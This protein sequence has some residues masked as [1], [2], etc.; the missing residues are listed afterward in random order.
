MFSEIEEV[1]KWFYSDILMPFFSDFLIS[2]KWVMFAFMLPLCLSIIML[3][4]MGILRVSTLRM[5]QT[6]MN[7]F[8][9]SPK[10]PI[11]I[12]NPQNDRMTEHQTVTVDPNT[13][14]I[15]MRKTYTKTRNLT[16]KERKS[17]NDLMFDD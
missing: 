1:I 8:V 3:F 4:M 11:K 5:P 13:G 16:Y 7:N 6:R 2:N 10:F 12:R 17:A 9:N 15:H 14:E